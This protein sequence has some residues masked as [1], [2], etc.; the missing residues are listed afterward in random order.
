[1]HLS[2]CVWIKCMTMARHESWWLST[3]TLLTFEL[4]GRNI[5]RSDSFLVI[6]P[7]VG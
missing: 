4:V 7:G 3:D 6:V 1:M 5:S 2:T